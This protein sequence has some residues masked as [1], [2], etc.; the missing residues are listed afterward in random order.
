MSQA[1]TYVESRGLFDRLVEQGRP[2]EERSRKAVQTLSERTGETFR[3]FGKL[4]QDTVEYES[5]SLMRRLG[6]AT[7][8]DVHVLST[9]VDTLARNVE[10]M[11]ARWQVELAEAVPTPEDVQIIQTTAAG[12]PER[13]RRATKEAR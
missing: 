12:A 11:V 5:K 10:E 9:R 1:Q 8:D 3:E 6:L 4:L 13:S 2:V 7:R